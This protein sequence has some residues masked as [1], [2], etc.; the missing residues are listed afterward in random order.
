MSGGLLEKAKDIQPDDEP[1][2]DATAE[3]A[4]ALIG[5]AVEVTEGGGLLEKAA[6]TSSAL[7]DGKGRLR[8]LTEGRGHI[9][10]YGGLLVFAASLVGLYNLNVP[11]LPG[12]LVL[13]AFIGSGIAVGF[14]WS[15]SRLNGVTLS[16]RQWTTLAVIWLVIG[17]VPYGAALSLGGGLSLTGT[18]FDEETNSYTV[19][20]RATPSLLGGS[21]EGKSLEIEIIH[22]GEVVYQGESTI[23]QNQ[24]DFA[25][26]FGSFELAL[27]DVYDTDAYSI[28]GKVQIGTDSEGNAL[29]RPKLVESTYQIRVRITNQE[30]ASTVLDSLSLTRTVNDVDVRM[31][32]VS[33]DRSDGSEGNEV[34]G[35]LLLASVGLSSTDIDA[36][37]SPVAVRQEYTLQAT[38]T[39][40][41]GAYAFNY[42]LISVNGNAAT[43]DANSGFGN[44]SGSIGVAGSMFSSTITLS[45]DVEDAMLGSYVSRDEALD[46]FGCYAYSV[47]V[48]LGDGETV[49]DV[50]YYRFEEEVLTGEHGGVNE[51][52]YLDP[53]CD[54]NN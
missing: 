20:Y 44:G 37:T 33:G 8:A 18:T 12:W 17:L 50:D 45:G 11:W 32:P 30:W 46:D 39:Y 3:E 24:E 34:K 49:T 31:D 36:E 48:E 21:V 51:R 47:T 27:T 9:F 38:L 14:G 25:G 7:G 16:T 35:V 19:V 41:D 54:P 29:Y 26:P 23:N 42:P 52:L 4:E 40:L 5:E 43:W 10:L 28:D 22:A 6:S 53:E 13:L 1:A 2:A 15:E